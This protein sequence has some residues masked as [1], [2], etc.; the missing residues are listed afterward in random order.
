[1]NDHFLNEDELVLIK[2]LKLDYLNQLRVLHDWTV[3][4]CPDNLPLLK[5]Y[6]EHGVKHSER[7]IKNLNMLIERSDQ[8]L[9]TKLHKK[10]CDKEI[11]ILIA[12]CYLHDLGMYYEHIHRL[13][14]Y[15]EIC[16]KEKEGNF[17]HIDFSVR[18]CWGGREKAIV[19][20][21]IRKYHHRIS[22][23]LVE[24][25]RIANGREVSINGLDPNL[26]R[27]VAQV[28]L[29][30]RLEPSEYEYEQLNNDEFLGTDK[31][32]LQLLSRLLCI[33]DA[34]DV[35]RERVDMDRTAFEY[36]NPESQ[37]HWYKHYYTTGLDINSDGISL[38]F[39]LPYIKDETDKDTV[40]RNYLLIPQIIFIELK[41]E[42]FKHQSKLAQYGIAIGVGEP[43]IELYKNK[44]AIMTDTAKRVS[45][46]SLSTETM[47]EDLLKIVPDEYERV[48]TKSSKYVD[49]IF[50]QIH[51][52][53]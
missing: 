4:H 5:D 26:K 24:S 33:S 12:A 31:L 45:P 23:E 16:D 49:Q 51:Y 15:E 40:K 34:L 20:E 32:R 17:P 42:E 28:C 53:M 36:I 41:V 3:E 11:Y 35:T 10:L 38:K 50:S 46:S 8:S 6:T 47:E 21:A 30:H 52:T 29:G 48:R 39:N 14:C 7:V 27:Y 19:I 25:G 43:D 9:L 1:M 22:S 13:D 2:G 44:T 37:I 18:N